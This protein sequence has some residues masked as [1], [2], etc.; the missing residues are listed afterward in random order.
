MSLSSKA[1]AIWLYD[2]LNTGSNTC[3]LYSVAPRILLVMTSTICAIPGSLT[4]WARR[5]LQS[6]ELDMT[7]VH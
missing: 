6:L 1:L 2:A 3:V 7:A 4:S 5:L